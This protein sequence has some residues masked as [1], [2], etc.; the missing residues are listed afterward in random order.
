MTT[1]VV[2]HNGEICQVSGEYLSTRCDPEVYVDF[3]R[4]DRVTT[5][6]NDGS[7]EWVLMRRSR[8][9]L[10]FQMIIH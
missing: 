8:V 9:T 5:G 7:T 6:K 2:E 3:R 1:K 10:A 4:G